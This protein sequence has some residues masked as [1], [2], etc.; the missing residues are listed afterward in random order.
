[1]GRHLRRLL[2]ICVVA[3]FFYAMLI[4]FG[5]GHSITNGGKIFAQ[6]MDARTAVPPT[7]TNVVV[8]TSQATWIAGCSSMT[9]SRDGW[10]SDRVSVE[11][12]DRSPGKTVIRQI[13]RSLTRMA[14]QRHDSSPGPYQG[15]IP[16]WRLNVKSRHLAQAW[17]FTEGSNKHQWYFSSSW[18]PP[19]PSGQGCP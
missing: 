4:V 5:T 15:T 19:G 7:A 6:I 11:F 17:A 1:M 13:D 14:W 18:Q 2:V 10:T 12:T 16:H 9:G 3:L 8:Q